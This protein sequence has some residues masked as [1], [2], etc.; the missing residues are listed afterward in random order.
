MHCPICGHKRT[1]VYNSRNTA[2]H[3]RIWRRRRCVACKEAFTTYEASDLSFIKIS[4]QGGTNE[5]YVRSKLL[6]SLYHATMGL[7]AQMEMIDAL[8]DTIEDKII[9][10]GQST[11]TTNEIAAIAASVLKRFHTSAY[12]RYLSYRGDLASHSHLKEALQNL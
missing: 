12:V 8:T 5:S 9:G 2:Q 7:P 10:L 1:E 6:I 4:K 11:V 3:R